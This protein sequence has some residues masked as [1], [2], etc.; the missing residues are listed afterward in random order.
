VLKNKVFILKPFTVKEFR[1]KP[2]ITE[3]LAQLLLVPAE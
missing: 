3:S 2:G 1:R